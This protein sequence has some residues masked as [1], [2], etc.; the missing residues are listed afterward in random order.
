MFDVFGVPW[1]WT[2]ITG[3]RNAWHGQN[4]WLL[5]KFDVAMVQKYASCATMVDEKE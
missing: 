3:D 5:I 2:I 1:E 4:V